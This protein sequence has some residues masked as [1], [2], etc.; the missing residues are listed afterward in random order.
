MTRI[1]V[2]ETTCVH[3]DSKHN[4]VKINQLNPLAKDGYDYKSIYLSR[5]EII[6]LAEQLKEEK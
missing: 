3:I 5:K 4:M 2:N 1:D 6:E